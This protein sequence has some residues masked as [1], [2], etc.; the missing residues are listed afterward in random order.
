VV[1]VTHDPLVAAYADEVVFLDDG[2]ITSR[3]ADPNPDAIFD[4]L[5]SLGE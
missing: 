2:L 3:M 1:M 5:K 4:H